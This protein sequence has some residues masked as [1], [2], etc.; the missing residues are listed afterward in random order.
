MDTFH[1]AMSQKT[2][3][4]VLGSHR[5]RD[6]VTQHW[7]L[8]TSRVSVSANEFFTSDDYIVLRS[9]YL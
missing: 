8:P 3:L 5:T 1:A 2:R 6:T 7:T 9:L 4:Y